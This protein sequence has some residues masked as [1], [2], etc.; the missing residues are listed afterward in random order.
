MTSIQQD[1]EQT[2]SLVPFFI[3]WSGQ[4]FSLV[5][6]GL[7]QFA[8]VWWLTKTT[9]SAAVLT[10]ATL[11]A[12]LPKVILGPVIGALVDRWSRRM[13]MIAADVLVAL[14]AVGLVV[15]FSLGVVQ[16]WH[17]YGLLFVRALGA[18]FHHP[19]MVASTTLMV[20]QRDLVR[21]QGMNQ[22][23]GGMLGLLSPML[24]A[25]L[26]E[27]LPMQS[28]LAIDVGTALLAILPICFVSIPQPEAAVAG[29]GRPS[30]LDD[31]RAGL[32]LL[33][34]R[35]GLLLIIIMHALVYLLMV[36]AYSL[37]PL[38]VSRHL[39]GGA[40]QLAWL[41]AAGVA[42]SIASGLLLT[43]WG[44]FRKRVV[45]M[46]LAQALSGV[47]WVIIGIA[48]ANC[49]LLVIGAA[50]LSSALN[51]MMLAATGAL[52][53]AVVPP[54]MQGRVTTLSLALVLAMTPIGLT[55]AGPVA[56]KVGVQAW[57]IVGGLVTATLGAVGF[58]VPAIMQLERKTA[59]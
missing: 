56:D 59:R 51:A 19:A 53:Q 10:F 18:A 58:S 49:L 40:L 33:W 47:S 11:V 37:L 5:G 7:A 42:G 45:T 6:S 2:E 38:L 25:L 15:L 14:A 21:T 9:G 4:A 41:Q 26:L 52:F 30:L 8:L 22:A 43:M 46:L 20:P 50:F 17:V 13:V 27:W 12:M 28:I 54:A 35:S 31:V 3:I 55:I 39:G 32:H 29:K 57:F 24:G 1:D 34:D 44:G 16:V 36:P 48:P 23:L